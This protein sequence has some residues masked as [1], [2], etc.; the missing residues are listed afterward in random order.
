MMRTGETYLSVLDTVYKAA[1]RLK[2]V[3]VRTPLAVNNNLSAVYN[4]QVYFKR[5]DL[6]RVRSYKIR[7]AYNKMSTMPEEDLSRGIVCVS[8]GNHAQGVA[9]A[10]NTMKV[11]GTILCL[12]PHR[13]KNWNR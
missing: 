10:C 13:D 5:E 7:G 3:C 6:Q 12:Y 2:N 1:E 9:F 11:K 8:A 4:T